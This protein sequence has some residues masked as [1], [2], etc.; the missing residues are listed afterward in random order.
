LVH[1]NLLDQ[2]QSASQ[3]QMGTSSSMYGGYSATPIGPSY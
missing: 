3:A 1:Q 2:T